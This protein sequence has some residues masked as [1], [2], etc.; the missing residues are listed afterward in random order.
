[1]TETL[2]TDYLVDAIRIGQSI[3]SSYD[4][5]IEQLNQLDVSCLPYVEVTN[6]DVNKNLAAYSCV[7]FLVDKGKYEYVVKYVGKTTNLHNRW[8]YPRRSLFG[9]P[10]ACFERCVSWLERYGRAIR[11]AW[12]PIE[13]QFLAATEMFLIDRFDPP[14]NVHKA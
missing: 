5:V 13:R 3:Q 14:W 6:R 10:H 1:M 7:Y 4:A 12:I 9:Q 2:E 11:I 8:N